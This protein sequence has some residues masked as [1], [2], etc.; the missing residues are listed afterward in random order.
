MMQYKGYVGFAEIDTDAGILFGRVINTRDT[1]TFQAETVPD[2]ERA[3]RDSVDDYLEFCAERGEDPEK[4][5]SGKFPVRTTPEVHRA[6]ALEAKRRGVSISKVVD[7]A[8][9]REVNL[10]S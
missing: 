9:R 10:L 8:I 7:Q 5:F 4:P 1:I 6:L 3:F 2:L